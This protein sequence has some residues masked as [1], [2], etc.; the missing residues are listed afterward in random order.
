MIRISSLNKTFNQGRL[1]EV[2]SLQNLNLLVEENDFVVIVGANG[3]GKS[4][5]LNCIAGSILPT[6]GSIIMDG[7]DVTKYADYKRS[8]WIARVFQNPLS[9]TAPD[10]SILENFR[11]ASLR[12]GS[13]S[14]TIGIN[15]EFRG[16][17][18]EKVAMLGMGLEAKLDQA[19][20]TLSGGQRQALTLLMATMDDLKI[21]LLDEP[22]AALDPR[23]AELV[24]KT[25]DRIIKD[26]RLTALM[27]THNIKDA[28]TYGNRVIQMT[29]GRVLRDIKQEEKKALEMPSIYEWFG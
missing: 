3:S 11:L 29:E 8:K 17:V 4:T 1:N 9:G 28:Y 23:S 2:R 15:E 18:K 20:G 27:V 12:T 22:T 5:L 26:Y 21:L 7:T 10:L 16:R 6:S 24:M 19:I 25:A 14:L 13:K